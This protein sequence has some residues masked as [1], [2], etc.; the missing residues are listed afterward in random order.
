MSDKISLPPARPKGPSRP[1]LFNT[2]SGAPSLSQ[3][4]RGRFGH[5]GHNE[6]R[7][8][9]TQARHVTDTEA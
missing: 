7:G 6:M 1:V 4:H 3:L 5:A 8:K 2:V 9:E